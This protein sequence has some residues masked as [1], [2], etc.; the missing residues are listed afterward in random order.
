MRYIGYLGLLLA[1][2]T[3]INI[4]QD[5]A[6][7]MGTCHSGDLGGCPMADLGGTGPG[8]ATLARLLAPLSTATVS[9]PQPALRW[10]VVDGAKSYKLDLCHDASC[11]SVIESINTF[12]TSAKPSKPLALNSVVYWRVSA[13]TASGTT[14]SAVWEFFVGQYKLPRDTS[15]LHVL[16]LDRDGKPDVA[17]GAGEGTIFIYPNGKSGLPDQPALTLTGSHFFGR[18]VANAGDVNG[19]GYGDLIAGQGND[20]GDGEGALVFL[21]GPGGVTNKPAAFLLNPYIGGS[22]AGAGDVNGD[23]YGDV[24]VGGGDLGT[25]SY[26]FLGGPDGVS[27]TPYG[28]PLVNS[29]VAAAGDVNGDG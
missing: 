5:H 27:A 16:D 24:L 25:A 13:T 26:L 22:V 18:S 29:P 11:T 4:P 2:C 7:G 8:P 23:G 14:T 19:D 3:D 17:I 1:A 20:E 21:G 28:P 10:V 9:S 6:D 15:W 12:G